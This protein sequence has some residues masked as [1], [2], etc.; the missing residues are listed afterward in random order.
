M[1]AKAPIDVQF[2][3]RQVGIAVIRPVFALLC[4]IIL[5]DGGGFGIVSVKT[6]EYIFYMLRSIWGI[7]K[8]DAHVWD[9]MT[10]QTCDQSFWEEFGNHLCMQ[11]WGILAPSQDGQGFPSLWRRTSKHKATSKGIQA[12]EVRFA[13]PYLTLYIQVYFNNRRMHQVSRPAARSSKT[14]R[15]QDSIASVLDWNHAKE[16]TSRAFCLTPYLV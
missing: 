9:S 11:G 4:N 14:I 5:E 3:Q 8:C 12:N 13:S 2:Q 15:E 10:L 16:T 1:Q 7:V 6:V